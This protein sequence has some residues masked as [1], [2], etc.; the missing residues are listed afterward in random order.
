MSKDNCPIVDGDPRVQKIK[1]R[2][3]CVVSNG[4]AW[5]AAACSNTDPEECLNWA[6][7]GMMEEVGEK[8]YWI[9]VE[10]EIPNETEV[11][12]EVER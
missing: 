3:P 2:I 4:G 5:N 12:G 7:E 11:Q 1:V 9:T 8:V 10:L 6:L